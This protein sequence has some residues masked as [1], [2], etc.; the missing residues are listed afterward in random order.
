[1]VMRSGTTRL[2]LATCSTLTLVACGSVAG[3]HAGTG[4]PGTRAQAS[5]HGTPAHFTP[6]H[7]TPARGTCGPPP[8]RHAW[9]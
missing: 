7:V 5:A 1:M 8:P 6:A 4:S 9:A 2:L 3:Q